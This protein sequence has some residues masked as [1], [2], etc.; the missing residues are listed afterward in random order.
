METRGLSYVNME[1]VDNMFE[2][3]IGNSDDDKNWVKFANTDMD[4][5]EDDDA[6]NLM[7]VE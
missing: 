3:V 6:Y 5:G 1:R 2:N 4:E 7:D